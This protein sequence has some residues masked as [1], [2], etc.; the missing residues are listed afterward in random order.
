MARQGIGKVSKVFPSSGN[1]VVIIELSAPL[2]SGDTIIFDGWQDGVTHTVTSMMQDKK[3]VTSASSGNVSI[4][5]TSTVTV[6]ANVYKVV[7]DSPQ[8]ATEQPQ[9]GTQNLGTV[10]SGTNKAAGAF[11][12]ARSNRFSDTNIVAT[13]TEFLKYTPKYAQSIKAKPMSTFLFYVL[14]IVVL[15]MPI[16][17]LL[18]IYSLNPHTASQPST[19]PPMPQIFITLLFS[20]VVSGIILLYVGFKV[21]SRDQQLS[22]T[23]ISKID[24]ATYNLNKIQGKFIPY[25]SQLLKSPISGA[26]CIHFAATIYAVFYTEMGNQRELNVVPVGDIGKGTPALF[27]DDSGY[28]AVDFKKAPDVDAVARVFEVIP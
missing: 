14:A 24:I 16:F 6:G 2:S 15:V 4:R 13:N 25:N 10:F 9:Q 23:P 21:F 11:T 1:T 3:Q 12:Y 5:L 27:T 18:Y 8:N 22:S 17:T 7:P 28:L 19:M 26:D 20:F